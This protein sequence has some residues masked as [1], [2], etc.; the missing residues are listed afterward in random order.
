MPQLCVRIRTAGSKSFLEVFLEVRD[1]VFRAPLTVPKRFEQRIQR[2]ISLP[3]A[4]L[5]V[6]ASEAGPCVPRKAD[7]LKDGLWAVESDWIP[8]G[9]IEALKV[10]HLAV[11]FGVPVDPIVSSHEWKLI[12]TLL[13]VNPY[14]APIVL[15]HGTAKDSIKAILR[16]GLL[17]S[18]GMFGVAV[19][20][21]SFW[22]AHRFATMTQDYKARPGAVFRC[23]CFW[24]RPYVRN[25]SQLPV[26]M[27][28]RCSG[29]PTYADHLERW[30]AFGDHIWLFPIMLHGHW[31]V[32][33]FE[34]AAKDAS[35]VVLDSVAFVD[36]KLGTYD[37][38]ERGH[39]IL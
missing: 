34:V 18:F 1:G 27:C 14:D 4:S 37:P 3:T 29:Q 10:P 24:T 35:K 32:R 38:C 15:Y 12:H 26:C 33:N 31:V 5:C 8:K 16:D 30:T 13:E 36:P 23:L 9:G 2:K 22:K 20:F 21:G 28:S 25:E 19:Y 39:R 7:N 11:I 17:A 6:I